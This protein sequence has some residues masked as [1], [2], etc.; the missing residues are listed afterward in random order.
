[1]Y[2]SII[3]LIRRGYETPA[4]YSGR[5]HSPHIDVAQVNPALSLSQNAMLGQKLLILSSFVDITAVCL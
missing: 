4:R 2:H 5:A 3:F 1:M